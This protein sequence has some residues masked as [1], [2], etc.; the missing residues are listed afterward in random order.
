MLRI[1]PYHPVSTIYPPQDRTTWIVAQRP[2]RAQ[3]NPFEPY[4]YFLEQERTAD[5]RIVDSGGI[6]LTNKE[7]PWHCLMCDLW[8]HTLRD[9]V[10]LG[11]IPAQ[12][13]YALARFSTRPAQLKLYN[14]GSFFDPAAIPVAD[15]PAI[16][17][18]VAFAERRNTRDGSRCWRDSSEISPRRGLRDKAAGGHL[19]D[20]DSRIT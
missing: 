11:A 14:S 17:Q 10:P 9:T 3:V 7:C 2:A 15:Y 20:P 19:L 4:G 18:R 5:A 16:A 12:I 1:H 13:D 8:K 6:L